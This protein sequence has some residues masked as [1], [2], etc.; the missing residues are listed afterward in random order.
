MNA[1]IFQKQFAVKFLSMSTNFLLLR[2]Q[3]TDYLINVSS[4]IVKHFWQYIGRNWTSIF[5]TFHDF[6]EWNF[7]ITMKNRWC[8]IQSFIIMTQRIFG[9]LHTA[10]LKFAEYLNGTVSLPY[11]LSLNGLLNSKYAHQRMQMKHYS[12]FGTYWNR[13]Y[14]AQWIF[15]FKF[16]AI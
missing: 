10:V 12:I 3:K 7:I 16:K 8:R 9:E 11:E 2:R 13:I 6:F 1:F 14:C 5:E 15:F 4:E